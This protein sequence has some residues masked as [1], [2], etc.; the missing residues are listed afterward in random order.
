MSDITIGAGDRLPVI[1]RTVTVDGTVVNLTGATVTFT[2]YDP[3]DMSATGVVSYTW[4]AGD[5]VALTVGNYFARFV[6]TLGS[7]NLSAPNDGYLTVNVSGAGTGTFSYSGD[8]SLRPL[9]AVRFLIQDTD[10][11]DPL[12]HDAEVQYLLDGVNDSVY[13]AAHD[14]CYA[15]ASRFNRLANETKQVGDLSISTTYVAKSSAYREMAERFLELANR[16]EPPRPWV[17]ANNLL[18]TIDRQFPNGHDTDFYLGQTDYR[19]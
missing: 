6:I 19:S 10:S 1:T 11:A 18:A 8:P 13:Q 9:D 3:S 5:A 7:Q 15:L 16:R 14:A 17:A 2:V 12:M 4:S